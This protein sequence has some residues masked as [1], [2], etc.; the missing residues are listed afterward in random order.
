MR[1][2]IFLVLAIMATAISLTA[3]G[4]NWNDQKSKSS[5]ELIDEH[6]GDG[7][8]GVNCSNKQAYSTKDFHLDSGE[9]V[10]INVEACIS[11]NGL[12]SFLVSSVSYLETLEKADKK[13]LDNFRSSAQINLFASYAKA[14]EDNDGEEFKA[15]LHIK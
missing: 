1:K 3:C 10:F 13:S 9:T 6:N 5:I 2:V 8:G 7:W 4:G 14:F 11:Y 15:I 12:E